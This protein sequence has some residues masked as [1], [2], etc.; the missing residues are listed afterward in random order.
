M[1]G[2]W[3]HPSHMLVWT[4]AP[5][6]LRAS[7]WTSAPSTLHARCYTWVDITQLRIARQCVLFQVACYK[8]DNDKLWYIQGSELGSRGVGNQLNEEW[9]KALRSFYLAT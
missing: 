2:H 9:L 3:L 4:S 7:K 8:G 6:T 1:G 5:S